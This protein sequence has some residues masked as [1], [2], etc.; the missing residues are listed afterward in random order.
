VPRLI[1]LLGQWNGRF[2]AVLTE[3]FSSEPLPFYLLVR[4]KTHIMMLYEVVYR[5][6][7]REQITGP[8]H[9]RLY[10]SGTNQLTKELISVAAQAKR[11]AIKDFEVICTDRSADAEGTIDAEL[12]I[13]TATAVQRAYCTTAYNLLSSVVVATQDNEA[14]YTKFLFD[15]YQ[16]QEGPMWSLLVETGELFNF[17]VQTN[18]NHIELRAIEAKLAQH[19]TKDIAS[20]RVQNMMN[21]YL[22]QSFMSANEGFNAEMVYETAPEAINFEQEEQKYMEIFQRKFNPIS[23]AESQ[24]EN[25]DEK[26]AVASQESARFLADRES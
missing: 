22:T 16:N 1:D 2:T 6:L 19:E 26:S 21:E 18:F 7:S 24:E 10:G 25:I 15:A 20:I 17:E 5:R 3:G 14:V 11:V 12:P 8:L 4:E 23:K 9:T 13:N